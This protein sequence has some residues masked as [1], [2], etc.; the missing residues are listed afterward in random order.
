MLPLILR[1]PHS[2]RGLQRVRGFP[3]RIALIAAFQR[4]EATEKM[5]GL[6]RVELP[7]NGLGNRCSIHLSY[8]P[9]AIR[10]L[11]FYYTRSRV[12][13]SSLTSILRRLASGIK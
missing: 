6:E 12:E 8:R 10:L 3:R 13:T 1:V 7:T 2:L 9:H 5:V 11:R 4:L